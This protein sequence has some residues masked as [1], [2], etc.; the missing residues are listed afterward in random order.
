MEYCHPT[1]LLNYR[2]PSDE[3]KDFTRE[4]CGRII[5]VSSISQ[6]INKRIIRHAPDTTLEGAMVMTSNSVTIVALTEDKDEA[7]GRQIER[8]ALVFKGR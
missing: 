5:Q 3:F 8:L 2:G 6:R 4:L 1:E 7:R